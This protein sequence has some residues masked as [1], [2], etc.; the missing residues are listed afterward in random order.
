MNLSR[1]HLLACS[2]TLAT[3]GCGNVAA[4]PDDAAVAPDAVASPAF[5]GASGFVDRRG[6]GEVTIGFGGE[7]GS[8]P[9]GYTPACVTVNVGQSLRF[10]GGFNTHPLSPGTSPTDD[11]GAAGSP[12]LRTTSGNELRFTADAAGEFPYYCELHFAGNMRG[13]VRVVAP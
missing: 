1:T 12:I 3:L 13:I 7:L 8:A 2:L 10:V 4:T 5:C 9:F 11:T 6:M